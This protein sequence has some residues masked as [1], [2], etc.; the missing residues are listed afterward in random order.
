MDTIARGLASGAESAGQQGAK[1]FDIGGAA[2]PTWSHN[3]NKPRRNRDS[4]QPGRNLKTKE[5]TWLKRMATAGSL[6]GM[7]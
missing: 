4:L 6:G 5:R 2:I 7:C 1:R 3:I